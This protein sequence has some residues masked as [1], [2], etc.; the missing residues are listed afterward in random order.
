VVADHHVEHH[1]EQKNTAEA[2]QRRAN[3]MVHVRRDLTS[4]ALVV[5]K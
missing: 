3:M 1:E 2:N 5:H 4:T